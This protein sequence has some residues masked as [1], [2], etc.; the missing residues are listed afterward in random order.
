MFPSSF[1]SGRKPTPETQMMKRLIGEISKDRETEEFTDFT[2]VCGAQK[3]P[4]HKIIVCSHS[5]VLRAACRKPFRVRRKPSHEAVIG[6]YKIEEQSP[7]LVRRMVEYFYR[8]DYEDHRSSPD[9]PIEDNKPAEPDESDAGHDISKLQLHARMFAL[10]DMYQVEGL[11]SLATAK[12]MAALESS[13]N[14]KQILQS[15]PDVFNLT[16]P[17]ARQL[18]DKVVVA[19]R[20]HR[21]WWTLSSESSGGADHVTAAYDQLAVDAPDFLKELLGSFLRNPISSGA[22]PAKRGEQSYFDVLGLDAHDSMA[23]M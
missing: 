16:P 5:P 21:L 14:M 4:V 17:S 2:I 18:R 10:A 23:K 3:F 1:G 9:I 15:V 19:L 6:E 13:T 8:G 7:L 11:Q 12:Y 22:A 20:S